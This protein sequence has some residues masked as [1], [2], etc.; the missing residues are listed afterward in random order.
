M[1][2]W[3]ATDDAKKA[4]MYIHFTLYIDIS[5]RRQIQVGSRE[6]IASTH[7]KVGFGHSS[8]PSVKLYHHVFSLSFGPLVIGLI[9]FCYRWLLRYGQRLSAKG[10][11]LHVSSIT[12]LVE[13][14]HCFSYTHKYTNTPAFIL[15]HP[16][17]ERYL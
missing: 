17:T 7:L 1:L 16:S 10:R 3:G 12:H 15:G 9:L 4:E 14:E 6:F 8:I 2:Y 5:I 13:G 11:V